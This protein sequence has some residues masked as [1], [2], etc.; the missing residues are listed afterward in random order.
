MGS[1]E[2]RLGR[3]EERSCGLA[4]DEEERVQRE[5]LRRLSTEDLRTLAEYLRRAAEGVGEPTEEEEE[6]LH[7]YE[8]I[9]REVAEE[10][11]RGR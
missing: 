1:I 9:R 2:K 3:L 6:V 4:A 5:T 10:M 11:A 7:R 8:A